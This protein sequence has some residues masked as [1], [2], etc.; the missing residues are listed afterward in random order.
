MNVSV[1][2]KATVLIN[3]EGE[4]CATFDE[5][6][7]MAHISEIG[8][9]LP[10]LP[11]GWKRHLV[12]TVRSDERLLCPVCVQNKLSEGWVHY[13]ADSYIGLPEEESTW[14]EVSE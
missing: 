2:V 10:D 3:C 8:V 13:R 11:D 4:G 9:D 14:F 1:K 6:E 5:S 12:F 7:R